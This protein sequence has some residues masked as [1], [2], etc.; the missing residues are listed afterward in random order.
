[1]CY[2]EDSLFLNK[3]LIFKS[4]SAYANASLKVLAQCNVMQEKRIKAGTICEHLLRSLEYSLEKF[5]F[6]PKKVTFP[7]SARET[8]L[9]MPLFIYHYE[10]TCKY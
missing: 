2:L 9:A 5:G 1:M 7:S 3:M 8:S 6:E 10:T 4:S